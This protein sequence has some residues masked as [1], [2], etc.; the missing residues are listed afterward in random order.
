[1]GPALLVAT[2]GVGHCRVAERV[3]TL[4]TGRL[5]CSAQICVGLSSPTCWLGCSRTSSP[6]AGSRALSDG[7]VPPVRTV[8]SILH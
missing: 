3:A 5:F 7:L 1:M 4:L 2:G 8:A 6:I